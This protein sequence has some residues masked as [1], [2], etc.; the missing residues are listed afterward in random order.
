MVPRSH[1][2][3]RRPSYVAGSSR[4][5]E[6]GVFTQAHGGRKPV[7]WGQIDVGETVWMKWSGGPIVAQAR[8]RS[9]KCIEDCTATQLRREV[10]GFRL[11]EVTDYWKSLMVRGPFF[12]MVVFL[13]DEEWL[14]E[15]RCPRARSRSE[16]WIVLDTAQLQR[17]WLGAVALERAPRGSRTIPDG[18]RFKV[19]RR[20]GFACVYCGRGHAD[21]VRLQIDHVVAWS[22]GGRTVFDNLRT[23]CGA[24]NRGKGANRVA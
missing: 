10:K 16:S 7:P 19:L 6:V 20:D 12:G 8:V 21:G 13:E 22:K 5:P 3:I 11:H 1:V 2:V 15:A 4:R 23:S 18:L 14:S 17:A 24:C 9:F